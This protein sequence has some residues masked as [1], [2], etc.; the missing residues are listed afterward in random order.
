MLAHTWKTDCSSCKLDY[1]ITGL[2][3]IIKQIDNAYK[4]D[5]S[6]SIHV[7]SVF[8]SDKLWK[9][10]INFFLGQIEDPPPAIEVNEE[11][12]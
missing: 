11:Y 6:A 1:Q 4:L 2:Y 10:V 12:K 7:H 8:S 5:L 9:A 3:C